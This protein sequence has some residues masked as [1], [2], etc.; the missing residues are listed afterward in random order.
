MTDE[1][2]T[3]I[4][5]EGNVIAQR[6]GNPPEIGTLILTSDRL[7]FEKSRSLLK[8]KEISL[9]LQL[10]QITVASGTPKPKLIEKVGALMGDVASVV[11]G[12]SLVGGG[13]KPSM[14][15]VIV[16]KVGY[17]I[18]YGFIVKKPQ[19]WIEKI[20]KAKDAL[21]TENLDTLQ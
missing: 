2:G 14:L 20:Q 17:E 1:I 13:R 12:I 21:K 15:K 6:H 8:K 5:K 11:G 19:V 7:I 3:I 18:Q 16:E 9:E 4:F 10:S